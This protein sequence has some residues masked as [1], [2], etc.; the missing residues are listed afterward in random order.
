[1]LAAVYR[2]FPLILSAY[3]WS[4]A[5]AAAELC[6]VKKMTYNN[7]SEYEISI[8]YAWCVGL[9]SQGQALL[10]FRGYM[11]ADHI[12]DKR[13][14][15]IVNMVLTGGCP[16]LV[17]R[18]ALP[19]AGSGPVFRIGMCNQVSGNYPKMD[20]DVQASVYKNPDGDNEGGDE[21][22]RIIDFSSQ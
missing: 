18:F 9:T 7:W 11:T 19:N 15:N 13:E 14:F 8:H 21:I 10:T 12:P 22:V 20:I 17:R 2:M 1:M 16:G 3:F 5:V 6:N 4:S